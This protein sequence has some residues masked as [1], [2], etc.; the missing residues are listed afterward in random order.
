VWKT[1]LTATARVVQRGR[2]VGQVEC[3][4]ADADG[5]LVARASSTCMTL[6]DAQAQGR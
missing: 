5:R 6:R 2:T 4:V 1:R 3:D